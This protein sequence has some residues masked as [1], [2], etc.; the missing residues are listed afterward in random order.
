MDTADWCTLRIQID[1]SSEIYSFNYP[2][3][4]TQYV[5]LQASDLFELTVGQEVQIFVDPNDDN[6]FDITG[7]NYTAFSIAKIK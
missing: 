3:T 7:S 5:T 6:N 2:V 1:E 4:G